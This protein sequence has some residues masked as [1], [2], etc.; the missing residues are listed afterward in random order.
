VVGFR[1]DAAD[2]L[3]YLGHIL[4]WSAL[5]KFLE[6]PEFRNLEIGIGYTAI[7]VE[8]NGN[9]AMTFKASNGINYYSLH[10]ILALLSS[11]SGRL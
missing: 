9:L 10:F 4:G 5:A 11:E 2:T 3:G 6:T 8:K 1:A 7:L